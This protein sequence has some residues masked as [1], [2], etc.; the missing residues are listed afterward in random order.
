MQVQHQQMIKLYSSGLWQVKEA[1]ALLDAEALYSSCNRFV[2]GPDNARGLHTAVCNKWECRSHWKLVSGEQAAGCV[3]APSL[4]SVCN[5][6]RAM[7]VARCE[8]GRCV[9]SPTTQPSMCVLLPHCC[10]LPSACPGG[11]CRLP[12]LPLHMAANVVHD[13]SM[14]V[15]QSQ[16]TP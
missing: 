4:L 3:R 5:V 11:H 12:S 13:S 16:L 2:K 6:D 1:E 14:S 7:Q 15:Y 10:C 8:P 9:T